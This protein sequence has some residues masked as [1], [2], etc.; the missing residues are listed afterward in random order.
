MENHSQDFFSR[1]NEVG[2]EIEPQKNP[3]KKRGAKAGRRQKMVY[4][5]NYRR[6]H[7]ND[8]KKGLHTKKLVYPK[9]LEQRCKQALTEKIFPKHLDV[10][11]V[12]SI[13]VRAAELLLE[14]YE[15]E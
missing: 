3:T 1:F 8:M 12:N 7:K 13:F 4:N 11:S 10:K 6:R 15:N 2:K 14:K 5:T 9:A